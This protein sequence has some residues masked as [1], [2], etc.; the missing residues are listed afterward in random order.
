MAGAI[1]AMTTRSIGFSPHELFFGEAPRHLV[2]SI[3]GEPIPLH[4]G[5][6]DFPDVEA[7][8]KCV[9]RRLAQLQKQARAN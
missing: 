3:I 2:P 6:E 5:D 1:N 8:V 4:L 7:Y 9:K